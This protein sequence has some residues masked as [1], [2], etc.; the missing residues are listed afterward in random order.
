MTSE[1]SLE[2]KL[3]VYY[4]IEV[5]NR[6]R[7][8]CRPTLRQR[9]EFLLIYDVACSRHD[10]MVGVEFGMRLLLQTDCM[11]SYFDGCFGRGGLL[12][13]QPQSEPSAV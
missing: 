1:L 8:T 9:N 10:G 6:W 2:D 4:F 13:N 7:F 11:L 12:F 3:T 5:Y